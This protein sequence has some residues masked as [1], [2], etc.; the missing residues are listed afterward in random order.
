MVS[1]RD[2]VHPKVLLKGKPLTVADAYELGGMPGDTTRA[3]AQLFETYPDRDL[4]DADGMQLMHPNDPENMDPAGID[5]EA[6]VTRT[7]FAIALDRVVKIWSGA[8]E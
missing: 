8:S 5:Y 6:L 7:S 1:N 3:T 2:I 4:V